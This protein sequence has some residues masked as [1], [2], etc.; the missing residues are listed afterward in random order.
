MIIYSLVYDNDNI[1]IRE[2]EG[3]EERVGEGRGMKWNKNKS[4]AGVSDIS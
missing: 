1:S 3:R 4:K 2:E